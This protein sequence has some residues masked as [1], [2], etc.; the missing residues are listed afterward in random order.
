[1]IPQGPAYISGMLKSLGHDVVGVN[2][3]LIINELS[4]Q[5]NLALA[6]REGIS[7]VSPD[8]IAV[9]GMVAE[10]LFIKDAISA[11][12]HFA[13]HTPIILGGSILTNDRPLFEVLRPDYGVIDEGE[14]PIKE[15]LNAIEHGNPVENIENIAYWKN[16]VAICNTLRNANMSLMICHFQITTS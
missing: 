14:V 12:R 13:P 4:A 6:V 15:L 7:S 10:Y 11:S 8:I 16:G 9:G 3:G 5:E 1:M 2:S